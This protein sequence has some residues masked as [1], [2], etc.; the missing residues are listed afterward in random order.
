M[1]DIAARLAAAGVRVKPPRLIGW[2]ISRGRDKSCGIAAR[3]DPDGVITI[4]GVWVG[5]RA[6][7]RILAALEA[8][9]TQG[10]P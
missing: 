6:I 8:T 5:K 3:T 2:D 4:T 1:T 10:K 9:D 7:D